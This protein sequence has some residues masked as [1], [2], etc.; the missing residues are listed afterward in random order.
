MGGEKKLIARFSPDIFGLF[1]SSTFLSLSR[2]ERSQQGFEVYPQKS[3][4]GLPPRAW[5]V[6]VEEPLDGLSPPPGAAGLASERDAPVPLTGPAGSGG[7]SCEIMSLMRTTF[8]IRLGQ[9]DEHISVLT[10]WGTPWALL[11]FFFFLIVMKIFKSI[12]KSHFPKYALPS[13]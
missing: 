6:P 10:A 4:V 11:R 5:Q 9:S 3:H 8:L 2:T 7:R 12:R 13:F 1:Q